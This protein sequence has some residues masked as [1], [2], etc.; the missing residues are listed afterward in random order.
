MATKSV[1]DPN[2]PGR[3]PDEP[4]PARGATALGDADHQMLLGWIEAISD[5]I[6]TSRPG[7]CAEATYPA[8]GELLF[9]LTNELS[10]EVDRRLSAGVAP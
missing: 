5:T 3:N 9:R 4:I 6:A 1:F 7:E 8:L 2:R 10:V